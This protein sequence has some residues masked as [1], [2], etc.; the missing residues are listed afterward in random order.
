MQYMHYTHGARRPVVL[1]GVTK[2]RTE[3]RIL[4]AFFRMIL[5]LSWGDRYP[6][7]ADI[8]VGGIACC[9]VLEK[10][11]RSPFA[12]ISFLPPEDTEAPLKRVRL[13]RNGAVKGSGPASM[14]PSFRIDHHPAF[15]RF[16]PQRLAL[17][18]AYRFGHYLPTELPVPQV[19]PGCAG[20]SLVSWVTN[21]NGAVP[22][23]ERTCRHA[24]M[25]LQLRIRMEHTFERLTES[26]RG[27]ALRLIDEAPARCHSCAVCKR[28]KP[29]HRAIAD[30]RLCRRHNRILFETRA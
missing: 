20:E 5:R 10:G 13:Y 4:E 25:L 23:W 30:T 17:L 14:D 22:A 1:H 8:H 19:Q 28:N 11:A 7:H 3:E 18:A 24:S 27:E 12:Q 26:E 21:G 9:I 2:R 6:S 16:T 15:A 29:G